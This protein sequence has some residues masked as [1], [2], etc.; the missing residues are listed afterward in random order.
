MR[1]PDV[2]VLIVAYHSDGLLPGCLEPL[3]GTVPITVV[4]NDAQDSTREIAQKHGAKYVAMSSNVGF[5]AAV[6]AGLSAAWN[7]LDDV[8]L[9]N[10]DAMITPEA[11]AALTAG[12]HAAGTRRAAVGP[13]L[14][15]PN[16]MQT[17]AWPMP[18]PSQVWLDALGAGRLWRGRQFITGAALL[19]NGEALAE[20]GG[21]DERYFLYAEEADWQMRAQR[22]GWSV[23]VIPEASATHIGA[24]SSADPSR[25][26][27]L[28]YDSSQIFARRWYGR[29][30]A[31]VM[32][33]GTIVAATR[34][35]L[36]HPAGRETHRTWLRL[37]LNPRRRVR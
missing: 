16:R 20:V 4:D 18:S 29:F 13:T 1:V 35:W 3:A 37:A 12:M 26:L 2:L 25:R 30:G 24:A 34:R 36:L 11:L 22:A 21:F 17:P 28:F 33:A 6:N 19:L 8:L 14:V 15:G 7:G 9:L 10:P 31:A 23:A 32:H 5:A 27:A